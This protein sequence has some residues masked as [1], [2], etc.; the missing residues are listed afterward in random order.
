MRAINKALIMLT[1]CA[2]PAFAQQ[3]RMLP[4]GEIFE[5]RELGA[6]LGQ[7]AEQV[8]VMVAMPKDMRPKAYQS[9][10]LA[11][12]DLILFLNGKR[13]KALKEFEQSYNAL[14]IGDTIKLGMRRKEERM[15]AT[16]TKVDPK[17]LP[18]QVAHRVMLGGDGKVTEEKSTDGGKSFSFSKQIGGDAED[19][20]PVPALAVIIGSEGGKVKIVDKLPIPV[21]GLEDVD[22]QSGDIL[23]TLNGNAIAS[24]SA[25]NS[26][27]E[28]IVVGAKVE[29]Q[30]LRK[31][32]S[33]T[34]SF[35]KPETK[36]Q[37][38]IKSR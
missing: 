5:F 34:A 14:A 1:L 2:L 6:I 17:D 19:L 22:L 15:V 9:I 33:M 35:N 28:K 32:K 24:V 16:F 4:A 30:Y 11:E 37:F 23:Q 18:Q 3:M 31:D 36:G 7:E 12:G 27:F 26:A 13:L 38:M 8:K 25:F 20:T 10:D 21:K 29:L